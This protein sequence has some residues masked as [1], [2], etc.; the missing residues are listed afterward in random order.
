MALHFPRLGG[1][2][3]ATCL[4]ITAAFE[5]RVGYREERI[6]R[7]FGIPTTSQDKQTVVHQTDLS[8]MLRKTLLNVTSYSDSCFATNVIKLQLRLLRKQKVTHYSYGFFRKIT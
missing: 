5:E 4:A 7:K 3:T 6:C 1:C 8:T 2:F